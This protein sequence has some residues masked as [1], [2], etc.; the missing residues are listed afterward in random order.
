MFARYGRS[1]G[2]HK[3]GGGTPHLLSMGCYYDP[4]AWQP[5]F[6]DRRC[7]LPSGFYDGES[8]R[9]EPFCEGKISEDV[10]HAWYLDP[11]RPCHPWDSRTVPARRAGGPQYSYAKATRYDD[12]VVQLG[13]LADLVV[14]CDPLITSLFQAQGPNTW[15][16]QFARFHRPVRVL[17]SMRETVPEISADLGAPTVEPCDPRRAAMAWGCQRRA[18]CPAT[19]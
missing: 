2:L 6:R 3:T 16:R 10:S 7:L 19:G 8:K 14:G 12:R 9:V 11:G 5:P 15:L 1:I 4:E 17:E 13:P 18:R